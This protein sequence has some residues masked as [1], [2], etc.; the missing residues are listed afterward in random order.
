MF[1]SMSILCYSKMFL[2]KVQS[3]RRPT[4]ANAIWGIVKLRN[5]SLPLHISVNKFETEFFGS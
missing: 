1:D 4:T 5:V 2:E 3:K